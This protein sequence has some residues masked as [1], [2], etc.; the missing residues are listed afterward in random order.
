M[1]RIADMKPSR[2]ASLVAGG[3][4]LAAW[5]ATAA[6][7]VGVTPA[8][9]APEVR[10]A[11][12]PLLAE[13]QAQAS[14]LRERLSATTSPAT[15]TR[16]PYRFAS[17]VPPRAGGAGPDPAPV[18]GSADLPVAPLPPPPPVLS[19]IGIA[20][21]HT[22]EGPRRTAIITSGGELYMAGPN[23]AVAAYRVVSVGSDAVELHDAAGSSLVLA[24]P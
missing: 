17:P 4:L 6:N 15:P 18:S 8:P 7:T 22:P 3:G 2:I 19:L 16:N 11:P 13:V 23:E 12:D 14:R 24:L 10:V 5:L 9:A 20:E 21:H 1:K